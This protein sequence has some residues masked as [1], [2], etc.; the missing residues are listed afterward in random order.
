[1]ADDALCTA[2]TSRAVACSEVQEDLSLTN[3]NYC[4]SNVIV[5]VHPFQA[6]EHPPQEYSNI[7][8]CMDDSVHEEDSLV[9]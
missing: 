9:G 8:M 2:K 4:R 1:M 3:I 7:N 5:C 6:Q